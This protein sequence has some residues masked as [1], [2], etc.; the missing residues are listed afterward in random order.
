MKKCEKIRKYAINR[1]SVIADLK[2]PKF[3]EKVLLVQKVKT[4]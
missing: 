2:T 4:V 1:L 3:L